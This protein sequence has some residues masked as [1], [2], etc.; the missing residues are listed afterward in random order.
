MKAVARAWR[1]LA[2]T[3]GFPLI[4]WDCESGGLVVGTA[5]SEG[6]MITVPLAEWLAARRTKGDGVMTRGEGHAS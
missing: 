6:S 3:D 4:G 5:G 1:R 2:P